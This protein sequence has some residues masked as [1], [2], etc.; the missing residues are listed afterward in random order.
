MIA[1]SSPSG[2]SGA[3]FGAPTGALRW[4]HWQRLIQR[5]LR[6]WG[7][8]LAGWL[9]GLA[10]MG[11]I[12]SAS[13]DAHTL[14]TQAL[15]RLQIQVAALPATPPAPPSVPAAKD[16][17]NLWASLPGASNPAPVWLNLQ[18]TLSA[19]GLRLLSLRPVTPI[20]VPAKPVSATPTPANPEA[21]EKVSAGRLSS[22]AIEVRLQ[23]R[24]EDWSRTWAALTQAG[25]L[26]VIEQIRVVATGQPA[27]VQIDAVLRLWMRPG[28]EEGAWPG[29][30]N[31]LP[32]AAASSYSSSSAARRAGPRGGALFVSSQTLAEPAQT[33]GV[34]A[35][36]LPD[37]PD[38]S[39]AGAKSVA[40]TEVLSEDP[41]QWPLAQVRLLG[42]WQQGAEH[43]AILSAG[44]HWAK[45]SQGQ[46]VTLEGHRVAAITDQGVR[47]QLA[48]GAVIEIPWAAKT[49]KVTK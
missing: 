15:A 42:L 18:Q 11:F 28:Q 3:L 39:L 40:V 16:S 23:G 31:A 34:D 7:F 19:N 22:Q 27:E 44:P 30:A 46:R 1:N 12:Y 9:L 35:G 38:A 17:Q 49:A 21:T 4:P 48:Q 47:L 10:G 2:V 20:P 36:G 8:A 5:W 37:G 6:R 33:T 45:V 32:L 41:Q 29:L 43:L 13:S 25:P 26:C 14:A 24:F